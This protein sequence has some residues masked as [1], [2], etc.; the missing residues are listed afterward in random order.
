LE[1]T[2]PVRAI[3]LV[4]ILL[5]LAGCGRTEPDRVQ[6]AAA[7]GAASG[8]TVGLVGGPVGVAAG[9]VIGGG[10][11]AI[12]GATTTPKQVDLGKPVWKQQ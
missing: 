12:A 6:G 3:T 2:M 7:A 1:N 4:S 8:A 10:A 11:G 9:A 5:L